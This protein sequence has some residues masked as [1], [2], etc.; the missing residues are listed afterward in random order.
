MFSSSQQC[1]S[2]SNFLHVIEAGSVEKENDIV[3][4]LTKKEEGILSL[5]SCSIIVK[6]LVVLLEPSNL[7]FFVLNEKNC[8]CLKNGHQKILKLRKPYLQKP[9]MRILVKL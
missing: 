8:T 3:N 9:N 7:V 2:P 5:R 4:I 6:M 1:L